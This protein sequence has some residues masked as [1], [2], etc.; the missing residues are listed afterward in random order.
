MYD[1]SEGKTKNDYFQDM[2]DEVLTWG[3]EPAMVTGDSWYSGV[4]NLK[5]I[6]NHQLGWLFALESNRTVSLEKGQWV[7]VQKLDIPIDGLVVWL[8]QNY[9]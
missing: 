3:L 9:L 1:K 7:Q 5:R 4:D 2:L 8:K 6:R